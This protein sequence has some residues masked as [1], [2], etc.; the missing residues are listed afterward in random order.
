MAKALCH[1]KTTRELVSVM[2]KD[3]IQH[4]GSLPNLS[5]E[6]SDAFFP[7]RP[8]ES[9]LMHQKTRRSEQ[10]KRWNYQDAVVPRAHYSMETV[11]ISLDMLYSV[12]DFT[13]LALSL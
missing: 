1:S 7:A 5:P 10:L 2:I 12:T 11:P 8:A 3:D 4:H 9:S 6:I 13:S